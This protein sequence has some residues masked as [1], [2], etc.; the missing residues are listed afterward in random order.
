MR[1]HHNPLI[2]RLLQYRLQHLS[3]VGY[4]DDGV[5]ILGDQILYDFHLLRR[6]RRR[7]TGLVGIDIQLLRRLVY[8]GLHTVEP[9]DASDFGYHGN[10]MLIG[11]FCG[12]RG[13]GKQARRG[14]SGR[15]QGEFEFHG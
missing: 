8:S 10:V 9:G 4:H 2:A 3:V 7:R 1:Q 13:G 11:L 15:E 6:I 14:Q 5:D 12:K